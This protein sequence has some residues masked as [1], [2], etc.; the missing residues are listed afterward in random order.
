MFKKLHL[1]LEC[2]FGNPFRE[3]KSWHTL[4]R[5]YIHCHKLL[6]IGWKENLMNIWDPWP[7]PRRFRNS[8]PN[9]SECKSAV[10]VKNR[11]A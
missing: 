6:A 8:G 3:S 1:S 5:S 7:K 11:T 10:T 9:V 2:S 4:H